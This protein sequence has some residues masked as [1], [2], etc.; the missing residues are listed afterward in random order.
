MRALIC[1]KVGR[2]AELREA[3]SVE[4][5]TNRRPIIEYRYIDP[6]RREQR[7]EAPWDR[8]HAD[9]AARSA[10]CRLAPVVPSGKPQEFIEHRVLAP[11]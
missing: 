10:A 6:V 1:A 7:L 2:A 8:R 11:R 5:V 4:G 3:R 9:T